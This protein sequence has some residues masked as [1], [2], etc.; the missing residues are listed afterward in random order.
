MGKGLDIREGN[1]EEEGGDSAYYGTE[2]LTV[3][4]RLD[5]IYY[6]M[7]SWYSIIGYRE[8][9]FGYHWHRGVSKLGK[10]LILLI[11]LAI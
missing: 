4:F 1:C 11:S 6:P 2:E 9:I 7:P 8:N 10:L 3:V 5:S